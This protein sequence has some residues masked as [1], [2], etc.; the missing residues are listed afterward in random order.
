MSSKADHELVLVVLTIHQLTM[1]KPEEA[2]MSIE[3]KCASHAGMTERV[4]ATEGS[5]FFE[6]LFRF[7]TKFRRSKS[8]ERAPKYLKFKVCRYYPDQTSKIFGR[9]EVDLVPYSIDGAPVTTSVVLD[10][11]HQQKSSV[12]ITVCLKRMKGAKAVRANASSEVT[13]TSESE[14]FHLTQDR[15]SS[16][17]VSD[18][19]SPEDLHVFLDKRAAH[20]KDLQYSLEEFEKTESVKRRRKRR[21]TFKVQ[22][23]GPL[24]DKEAEENARNLA[25]FFNSSRNRDSDRTKS[26]GMYLSHQ[27]AMNMMK[28]ITHF[29]WCQSPLEQDPVC[30]PAAIFYASFLRCSCFDVKLVS[31]IYFPRIMDTFFGCYEEKEFAQNCTHFDCVVNSLHLCALLRLAPPVP[32]DEQRLE[33][34]NQRLHGIVIDQFSTLVEILCEPVGEFIDQLFVANFDQSHCLYDF[35]HIFLNISQKDI[36]GS[37]WELV[38]RRCSQVI[39]ARF[40]QAL[41]DRPTF[42]TFMNAC[43]LNSFVTLVEAEHPKCKLTKFRQANSVLMMAQTLRQTPGECD[44]ICPDL[45]KAVVLKLLKNQVPDEMQPILND[46]MLFEQHFRA[47][48]QSESADLLPPVNTDD[49][50]LIVNELDVSKWRTVPIPDDAFATMSFLHDFFHNRKDV[51]TV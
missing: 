44:V 10:S 47:I 36:P 23:N 11:P 27:E 22:K 1:P 29:K 14:A 37:V 30:V 7:Q 49:F 51:S 17:D 28:Q 9:A 43:L 6:K 15:T 13:L 19:V 35:S 16:W 25:E 12:M 8:N 33:L 46:N 5:V 45:P 48:I 21:K 41:L 34:T 4:F 2:L 39:D 26:V 24:L 38:I 3:W 18:S 40:V 31:N 20:E 42:N 32:F 50:K